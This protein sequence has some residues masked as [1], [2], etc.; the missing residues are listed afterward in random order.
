MIETLC[1][2]DSLAGKAFRNPQFVF[3]PGTLLRAAEY[4]DCHF[5]GSHLYAV[6]TNPDE[7]VLQLLYASGVRSFDVASLDEV[8]LVHGLFPDSTLYFMHPVKSRYAIREA[9]HRFGVRHFSLDSETELLKILAETN[10]ARDLNLHVRLSIPNN[11]AE[12]A[13][14]EKFGINLQDAPSFIKK[15]S[16]HA[17]KVGVCFHV[18]S[19][20]M[21]PD[22]YRIAMR[23]V[24]EVI[25]QSAVTPDF[26]NVGGGFPSVYPG[27]TP[28]DMQDY[29][30]AI[31]EEFEGLPNHKSMQ[32]LAEP[33]RALVAESISLIVRVEMRKDDHLYIND[34]TYGSLF[35]AGTPGFI[36]PVKLIGNK[37]VYSSDLKP[38]SFYGPTC[39]SLDYMKGPFYL[40]SNIGEGD[41]IEIGQMGAYGRALATRFNGFR[42]A[43]EMIHVSD[44]PL[45]TMYGRNRKTHSANEKLE[46][47]AA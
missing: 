7:V 26:F 4:F 29:F 1:T 36:F 37:K 23:M 14:A 44:E 17:A 6:K 30:D 11:Y 3:R 28:P 5:G 33:G 2:V 43:D 25:E 10:N 45:M 9:Y 41:L 15:V 16:E 42:C 8:S 46:I 22:A 47:I 12:L 34:G 27:L 20:C 24:A 32:L 13:L 38:F 31:H 35:D 40:P 19:Q 21:H 39:D 18:G